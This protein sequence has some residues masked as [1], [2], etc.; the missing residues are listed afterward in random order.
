M[1]VKLNNLY[2]M[3]PEDKDA[4]DSTN[5]LSG[6]LR[7]R[8]RSR[9]ILHPKDGVAL[10]AMLMGAGVENAEPERY[11]WHGLKRGPREFALFQY[12]LSG[13]GRLR[14]HGKDY[15][16]TQGS[17]MLL[18]VP[19]DHRYWLPAGG[20]WRF[21]YLLFNGSELVRLWR[22]LA[23]HA[24]PVAAFAEN[25]PALQAAGRLCCAALGREP[26]SRWE[27]SAAAYEVVMRLMEELV[28][29]QREAGSARPPEV[30][31]ALNFA[32]HAP[33]ETLTVDSLAGAA[34]LSRYYFTRLFKR[35][36]G[37][38]P[39]RFLQLERL[40]LSVRLLQTTTDPVKNI[41]ARCGFR[42]ANYFCRAFHKDYGVTPGVFRRNAVP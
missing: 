26:G 31:R 12:T 14:H 11:D 3:F 4:N 36:E 27:H 13:E 32:A 2:A 7:M 22:L 23:D 25:S 10:H 34:G 17:A 28:A 39:G 18:H 30:Q 5:V 19:D 40:R 38:P 37:M 15:L 6:I 42:D 41:A 1:E 33:L 24:G 35:S 8:S 16:V 21:F 9:S 20:K 29:W